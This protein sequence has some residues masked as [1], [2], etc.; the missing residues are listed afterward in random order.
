MHDIP[1]KEPRPLF[2]KQEDINELKRGVFQLFRADWVFGAF[3]SWVIDDG[4]NQGMFFVQ[5][6]VN[7]SPITVH[8]L[9][10]RVVEGRRRLGAAGISF[11]RDWL[12]IPGNVVRSTPVEVEVWFRKI[13]N[14]LTSGIV[15]KA[16]VHRYH[17]SKGVAA[18]PNSSECLPPY[19]FIT[20]AASINRRR[21]GREGEGESKIMWAKS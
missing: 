9:G 5:P 17:V 14:F 7:Y 1:Q 2:L 4:H 6:R 12:A 21:R 19:D 16:G 20:R 11:R 8:F 15:V 3:Q 10:E 13:A 18:D